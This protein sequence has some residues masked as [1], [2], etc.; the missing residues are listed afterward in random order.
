MKKVAWKE[1]A[2][3]YREILDGFCWLGYCCNERMK[4]ELYLKSEMRARFGANGDARMDINEF[5]KEFAQELDFETSRCPAFN[6]LIVINRGFN[7]FSLKKD[8]T[9]GVIRC[10]CCKTS[11]NL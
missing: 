11:R 3:W 7:I 9:N 5:K 6:Q 10:P 4:P 1:E 2:P 8:V